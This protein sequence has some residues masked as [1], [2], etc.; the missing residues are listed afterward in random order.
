MD[1]FERNHICNHS[2]DMGRCEFLPL[3][4]FR[5]LLH[6]DAF[7]TGSQ[8]RTKINLTWLSSPSESWVTA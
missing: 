3:R 2:D 4:V 6:A 1:V 8:T 7:V 5:S